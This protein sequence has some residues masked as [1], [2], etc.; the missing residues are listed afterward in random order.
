MDV[1]QNQLA[2]VIRESGEIRDPAVRHQII[3]T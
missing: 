2:E 3:S 1:I